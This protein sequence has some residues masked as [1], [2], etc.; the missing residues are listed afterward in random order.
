MV[1]SQS[2]LRGLYPPATR[3]IISGLAYAGEPQAVLRVLPASY[4]FDSPKSITLTAIPPSGA[5]L[6]AR[7]MFSG[8]NHPMTR[9]S[10]SS[11]TDAP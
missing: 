5:A 3:A 7:R 8:C 4:M 1:Y 9:P 11:P 10:A 6:S 2:L